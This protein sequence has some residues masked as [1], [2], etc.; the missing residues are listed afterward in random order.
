MAAPTTWRPE[1][2][3]FWRN[4]GFL[5]P[6]PP[7]DQLHGDG[8][9]YLDLRFFHGGATVRAGEVEDAVLAEGVVVDAV[10]LQEPYVP[11]EPPQ[12]RVG[13]QAHHVLEE[14]GDGR[15]A[16]PAHEVVLCAVAGGRPLR[17][18]ILPER[19]RISVDLHDVVEVFAGDLVRQVVVSGPVQTAQDHVVR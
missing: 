13:A 17:S 3:P 9:I 6:V 19:T 5:S 4:D 11:Q 16:A 18:V 7:D 14:S 1:S 10:A 15:E 8:S 2:S 12:R